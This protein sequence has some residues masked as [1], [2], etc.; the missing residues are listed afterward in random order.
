MATPSGSTP[1]PPAVAG[2]SI[3]RPGGDSEFT[4]PGDQGEQGCVDL[5]TVLM[6]ETL[7]SGT[8]LEPEHDA[9]FA[10]LTVTLSSVDVP[11]NALTGV[12][13]THP[14]SRRRK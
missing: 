9:R 5:L 3:R 11:A 14:R 2:S 4:T 1:T 12:D 8:R 10:D 7:T 6:H 13:P